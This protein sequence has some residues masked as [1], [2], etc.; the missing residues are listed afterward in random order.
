MV[1][2][3]DMTEDLAVLKA[4]SARELQAYAPEHSTDYTSD[5]LREDADDLDISDH[6]DTDDDFSF[7]SDLSVSQTRSDEAP[8]LESDQA[9]ENNE[10]SSEGAALGQLQPGRHVAIGEDVVKGKFQI[11]DV[12][13]LLDGWVDVSKEQ[14]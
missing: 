14:V 10:A 7:I 1:Q 9:T 12:I 8:C 13:D 11:H 6:S 4:L 2:A 3:D 5:H